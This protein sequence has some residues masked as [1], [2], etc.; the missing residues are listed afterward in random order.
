M[1]SHGGHDFVNRLVLLISLI[2]RSL[3]NTVIDA[4]RPPR[5]TRFVTSDLVI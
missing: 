4:R 3:L 2:P 1:N 5:R